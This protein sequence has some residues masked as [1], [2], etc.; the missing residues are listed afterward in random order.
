[1]FSFVFDLFL[2]YF[3][4]VIFL[5]AR[6][7]ITADF[8]SDS[9][10]SFQGENT[11][12]QTHPYLHVR[13]AV[14]QTV[15]ICIIKQNN[16]RNKNKKSRNSGWIA[17]DVSQRS[18]ERTATLSWTPVTLWPLLSSFLARSDNG[19]NRRRMRRPLVRHLLELPCKL[20]DKMDETVEMERAR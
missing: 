10:F 5:Y 6:Y 16:K 11:K 20:E 9:K 15:H 18:C 8:S 19:F 2:W 17:Y 12:T 3:S 1:M 7:V 13:K 14:A 4:T